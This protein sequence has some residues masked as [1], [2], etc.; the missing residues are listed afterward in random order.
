MP[1]GRAWM[2]HLLVETVIGR[3]HP[4]HSTPCLAIP[5]DIILICRATRCPYPDTCS[6]MTTLGGGYLVFVTLAC[7][8]S[9]G[10]Q[11][12]YYQLSCVC[13]I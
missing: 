2:P 7:P 8:S 1:S 3:D 13:T 11:S 6:V 4:G 12:R 5:D 10:V 9:P